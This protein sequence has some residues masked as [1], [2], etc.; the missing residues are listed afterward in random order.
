M[1]WLLGAAVL[2]VGLIPAPVI[3]FFLEKKNPH[4]QGKFW[5][6]NDPVAILI[7]V[8]IMF[9]IAT[10]V[11]LLIPYGIGKLILL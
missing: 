2:I 4:T 1:T 9:W 6:D 7:P 8:N 10:G 5:L 3:Y 11:V